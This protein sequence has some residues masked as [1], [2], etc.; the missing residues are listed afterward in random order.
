[1]KILRNK[2]LMHDGKCE[3]TGTR[4]SIDAGRQVNERINI[5]PERGGILKG[6]SYS[7][8][9]INV[10]VGKD[11]KWGVQLPPST[12]M[13]TY[14]VRFDMLSNPEMGDRSGAQPGKTTYKI[15]V[16]EKRRARF[17]D[18]IVEGGGK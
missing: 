14:A 12:V 3:V 5:T 6:V 2:D 16:P 18:I 7:D 15:N 17:E 8:T 13:G 4:A 9:P 10:M 11:G 1:M